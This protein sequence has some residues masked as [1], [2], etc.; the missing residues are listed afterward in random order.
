MEPE[1]LDIASW[2]VVASAHRF[3][4]TISHADST[5]R[6]ISEPLG[7]LAYTGPCHG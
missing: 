6:E 4:N 7:S 2:K 3:A 5:G 1:S